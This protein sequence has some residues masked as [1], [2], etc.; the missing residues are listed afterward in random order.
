MGT[1]GPVSLQDAEFGCPSDKHRRLS[2]VGLP[3]GL[4]DTMHHELCVHLCWGR[5]GGEGSLQLD[6]PLA[7]Q[8][9]LWPILLYVICFAW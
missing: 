3:M 9:P 8:D 5:S 2:S 7:K 4:E 6:L 1:A